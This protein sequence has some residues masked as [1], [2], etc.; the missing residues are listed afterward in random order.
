MFLQTFLD[1]SEQVSTSKTANSKEKVPSDQTMPTT[2]PS[3]KQENSG[4]VGTNF[5]IEEDEVEVDLRMR[6]PGNLKK[7]DILKP[8]PRRRKKGKITITAFQLSDVSKMSY[9]LSRIL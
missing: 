7:S 6:L 4:V 2:M 9:S 5:K 3:G 8:P 1:A